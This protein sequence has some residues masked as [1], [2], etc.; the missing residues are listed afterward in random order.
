M[1]RMWCIP[2]WQGNRYV[3]RRPVGEEMRRKRPTPDPK[4][5]L[6]GFRVLPLFKED[7]FDDWLDAY[8]YAL[9][10][11]KHRDR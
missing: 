3:F 10:N 5:P 8:N 6:K 4:Y 2:A 11:G 9:V 7:D 1:H